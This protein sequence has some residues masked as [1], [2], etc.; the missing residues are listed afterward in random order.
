MKRTWQLMTFL[1]LLAAIGSEAETIYLTRRNSCMFHCRRVAVTRVR[2]TTDTTEA[3]DI[4]DRIFDKVGLKIKFKLL[5]TPDLGD[6]MASA[7]I[8]SSMTK[9][10]VIDKLAIARLRRVYNNDWG[11]IFILAH[12]CAHH[13][14]ADKLSY[15]QERPQDERNADEF[16]GEILYKLHATLEQTLEAL[17]E[18]VGDAC[19]D[20]AAKKI[21]LADAEAGWRKAELD[22]RYNAQ[23]VPKNT[24]ML[25]TQPRDFP[26][27][28]NLSI[29]IKKNPVDYAPNWNFINQ[30]APLDFTVEN[31]VAPRLTGAKRTFN[32]QM[33]G[34]QGRAVI[35]FNA[36]INCEC[37]ADLNITAHAQITEQPQ[38]FQLVN[39]RKYA[40]N[41]NAVGGPCAGIGNSFYGGGWS[42]QVTLSTDL[43]GNIT[44]VLLFQSYS[45]NGN[46][47]YRFFTNPLTIPVK[48]VKN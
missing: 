16:A 34:Y 47:S 11:T 40:N 27:T 12:E 25:V 9:C 24:D 31:H 33:A 35:G 23:P 48:Y 17:D 18:I 14:S 5:A 4:I 32:V 15:L 20:H 6:N 1:F 3:R 42:G 43:Q 10:I 41:G 7:L 19:E 30:E 37:I 46:T 29:A 45:T 13:L 8:D 44:A 22:Y 26:I 36:F 21:R 28:D 2:T 39:F 38:T